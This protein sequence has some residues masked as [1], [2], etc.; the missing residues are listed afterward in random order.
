MASI[1]AFEIGTTLNECEIHNLKNEL[2]YNKRQRAIV[3]SFSDKYDRIAAGMRH[4][5]SFIIFNS[6][7]GY[8]YDL[9]QA[10]KFVEGLP[11]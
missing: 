5:G 11:E 10:E 8:M 9:E 2:A 1:G 3:E 7:F 4:P 6:T